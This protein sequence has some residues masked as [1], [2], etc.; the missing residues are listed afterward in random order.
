M[1]S[2]VFSLFV[3]FGAVAEVSQ[4]ARKNHGQT[5][6]REE[7]ERAEV[8]CCKSARKITEEECTEKGYVYGRDACCTTKV[9]RCPRWSHYKKVSMGVC[10]G[11]ATE[12]TYSED[13]D[14]VEQEEE[15]DQL[16]PEQEARARAEN[17]PKG[18]YLTYRE[19]QHGTVTVQW[20]NIE[21]EGALAFISPGKPVPP[22][23][24]TPGSKRETRSTGDHTK[25]TFRNAWA[26]F[27]KMGKQYD[28]HLVLTDDAPLDV[29]LLAGDNTV[30][31]LKAGDSAELSGM[32]KVAAISAD[33][34]SFTNDNLAPALFIDT[35]REAQ[36]AAL[37]M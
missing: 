28:G 32:V 1:A 20:S 35:A 11:G 10:D 18:A 37:N 29:V 22:F 2:R 15:P 36:S 26:S 6:Q 4:A 3:V 8:C 7:S 33:S 27:V 13:Q 30:V 25:M 5:Q 9:D 12:V 24:F 21:I 17:D 31:R 16:T 34:G 23:K 14:D 19:I